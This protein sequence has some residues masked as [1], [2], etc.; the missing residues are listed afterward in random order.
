MAQINLRFTMVACLMALLLSGL[1]LANVSTFFLT[2]VV[3]PDE[4]NN[5]VLIYNLAST[6]GQAANVVLGQS[7]FSTNAPGTTAKTMA[8]PSAYA[9]DQ[10]GNLYISDTGNCRVLQFRPPFTNGEA[11]RIVFGEPDANTSCAGP[12]SASSLSYTSGIAFDGSGNL[13]VADSGNNRVLRFRPPFKTGKAADLVVGQPDF[14][15]YNCN[16]PSASTMCFPAGIAFDSY[17]H[18][19]VSDS[20]NSRVLEFKTPQNNIAD[21][22]LGQPAAAGL[23]SSGANNGGISASTL[24]EP[25]GIGIDPQNRLWVADTQNNRVLRFDPSFSNGEPATL[26]LGQSD[27]TSSNYN[28]GLATPNAMTMAFP[29]GI[30]AAGDAGIWVGDTYN[31]RTVQFPAPSVDGMAATLVLGQPDFTH[32]QSNQG[33]LDPSAQTESSPFYNAGPSL[34]ALAVLGGLAGGRQWLHRLRQ[35]S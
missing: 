2:N 27:F 14:V 26:V 16:V 7:G 21:L 3:V 32:N 35:R 8:A 5:R 34:I 30:I 33:N 1:A 22:E 13:W 9:M 24:A 28:Q 11:A 19:W 15:S 18:L 31:N 29:L 25:Q 20:V 4:G 10:V 12:L 6:D 23:N 17:D